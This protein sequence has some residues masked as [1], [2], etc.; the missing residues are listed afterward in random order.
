M[1]IISAV[2]R[3]NMGVFDSAE[4]ACFNIFS[5]DFGAYMC[6]PSRGLGEI[7]TE[8]SQERGRLQSRTSLGMIGPAGSSRENPN[9][10]EN[11]ILQDNVGGMLKVAAGFDLR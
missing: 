4:P 9:N 3:F 5:R 7:R 8:P 6:P 11:I 1:K 2:P 10:A